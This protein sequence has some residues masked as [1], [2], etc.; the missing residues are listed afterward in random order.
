[1]DQQ[2]WQ[3]ADIHQFAHS[4]AKKVLTPTLMAKGAH[5]EKFGDFVACGRKQLLSRFSASHRL[6]VSMIGRN[7]VPTEVF[8]DGSAVG[9]F[10]IPSNRD[11]RDHACRRQYWRRGYERSDRLSRTVPTE[12]DGF[13]DS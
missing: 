10:G 12:G 9:F 11:D 2:Q 6:H 3:H 13:A 5:H 1:M 4:S 7:A 8:T